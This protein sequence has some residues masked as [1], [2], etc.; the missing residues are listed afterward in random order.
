MKKILNNST[1]SLAADNI[2]LERVDSNKR[3]SPLEFDSNESDS[4]TVTSVEVDE[5]NANTLRENSQDSKSNQGQDNILAKNTTNNNQ[6][7][8][9]S[10]THINQQISS[11]EI[12]QREAPEGTVKHE[13]NRNKKLKGLLPPPIV[14]DV[15]WRRK[16]SESDQFAETPIET[17]TKREEEK[18]EEKDYEDLNRVNNP[19]RK[20]KTV[21]R[22]K[23]G[24]NKYKA[25][26]KKQAKNI[27]VLVR[28]FKEIKKELTDMHKDMTSVQ[29]R[30]NNFEKIIDN[31]QN[32]MAQVISKV[33][34]PP[35]KEQK[36]DFKESTVTDKNSTRGYTD[37]T[38]SLFPLN[39]PNRDDQFTSTVY[40]PQKKTI[41]FSFQKPELSHRRLVEGMQEAQERVIESESLKDTIKDQ[42]FSLIN[43]ENTEPTEFDR[44]DTSLK[45]TDP[46]INT[47]S[48]VQKPLMRRVPKLNI[49]DSKG[50]L[51]YL[52][53]NMTYGSDDEKEGFVGKK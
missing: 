11:E 13:M 24:Y 40:L 2:T 31:L 44:K 41:V 26:Y 23:R 5:D 48:D 29:A 12:K 1:G 37:E 7:L 8:M 50:G 45:T 38:A 30:I 14:T 21:G 6:N 27:K 51:Q 10:T 28:G 15:A 18:F 19:L 33:K 43:E 3:M 32:L 4:S 36:Q 53:K 16:V 46:A 34:T 22:S 42:E 17:P 47:E 35:T 39:S 52:K 25:K 20:E 49:P 9:E